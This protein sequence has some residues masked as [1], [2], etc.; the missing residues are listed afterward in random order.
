MAEH[1]RVKLSYHHIGSVR[2]RL[3]RYFGCARGVTAI[4]FAFVAPMVL[5]ILLAALQISTIYVAQSYLDAV[6]E[7]AE[8]IVLTNQAT[9]L[10]AAQFKTQLCS[11]V[12]AL[13][14]CSNLMVDLQSVNC[15]GTPAQITT[16][17]SGYQPQFNSAGTPTTTPTFNAGA[18]GATMRLLVMYQ[19]PVIT[20]PLLMNPNGNSIFASYSNGTRLLSAVQIFV[21]EPCLNTTTNCVAANG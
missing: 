16:C 5:A 8:R 6:T 15:A 3:Q 11:N 7:A 17:I 14:N 21:E 19:W 9:T 13:F 10:T 1:M 4:E 12:T 20:G 18:P 2:S